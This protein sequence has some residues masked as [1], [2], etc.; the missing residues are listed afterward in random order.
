MSKL[1]TVSDKQYLFL[2]DILNET[3][4]EGPRGEGWKSDELLQ[5]I[6][7]LELKEV[8]IYD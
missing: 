2:M 5:L 7:A 6:E 3:Q 8:S 1:L 4:D